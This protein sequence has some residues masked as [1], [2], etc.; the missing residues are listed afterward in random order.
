MGHTQA[1]I[2]ACD[3]FDIKRRSLCAGETTAC[4]SSRARLILP[5]LLDA[6]RERCFV[7]YSLLTLG[8][9]CH[10]QLIYVILPFSCFCVQTSL[11]PIQPFLLLSL[12]LPLFPGCCS[13]NFLRLS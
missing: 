3:A 5:A 10:S 12:N 1:E 8:L 11:L 6:F 2:W 7:R 4:E 13:F 9:R